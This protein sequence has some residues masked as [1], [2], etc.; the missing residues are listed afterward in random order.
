VSSCH[1]ANVQGE[2]RWSG[3]TI[4][5]NANLTC[6]ACHCDFDG[7]LR[8]IDW[9]NF[10]YSER[11]V[12]TA[13]AVTPRVSAFRLAMTDEIENFNLTFPC[14]LTLETSFTATDST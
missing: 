5:V 2:G 11:L 4:F 9:Q 12:L 7:A 1:C 10:E 8:R 14:S 3:R 6:F 13:V